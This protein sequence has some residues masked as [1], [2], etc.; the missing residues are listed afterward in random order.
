MKKT[1]LVIL[2]AVASLVLAACDSRPTM[3]LYNWGEYIDPELV[4]A[5]EKEEGIRVNQVMFT[6][7]ELA[8]TKIQGGDKYDVIIPSEYGTEHLIQLDL[9]AKIDWTKI[10]AFNKDTE[11]ASGLNSLLERLKNETNG[12]DFL[13][14]SVP[15][16]WGNVGLLYNKNKVE[17]SELETRNWEILKD[18]KYKVSLYD[19]SREGLLVALKN[20][21]KSM[22]SEQTDEINAA[23]NWLIDLKNDHG[24]NVSFVT[25]Q[26]LDQMINPKQMAYDISVAY[27][28]DSVYLMSENDQLG[29]YVPTTGTNI[30]VDGMVIPKNANQEFA[31]KFINFISRHENAKANA[32]FIG[33]TSPFTN[34]IAELTEEGGEFADFKDAYQIVFHENDEIYRHNETAKKLIDEAWNQV[35]AK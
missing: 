5:F 16:F 4:K 3:V 18:T 14:Y 28:G 11:F 20:A 17:K 23:K 12:Y 34:I 24:N 7:N 1:L 19:T 30:W 15:Y 32:E 13:E 21:G 6:S 26:I 8:I 22:N 2:T 31:Y 27:S 35:K 9:L 33:Y 25:D 29:Y 10:D